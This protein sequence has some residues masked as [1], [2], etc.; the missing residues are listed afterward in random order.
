MRRRR[1]RHVPRGNTLVEFTLVGIPMIFVLISTF[2]IARGMW[3]YHT[4]AYAMKDAARYAA[5]HGQ[6]C[7]GAS[8]G[9]ALRV[10]DLAQRI[11]DAGLGLCTPGFGPAPNS[12]T[13]TIASNARSIVCRPDMTACL[14][15]VT[16]FPTAA[17]CSQAVTMAALPGMPI[18][19]TAEYPFRSAISMFWPGGGPGKV[20]GLYRFPAV[21]RENILF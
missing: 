20:F 14:A 4:M 5:V 13:V 21:A 11:C 10:Q 1:H 3:L 15:D 16:C 19:I 18:T 9:C 7:V 8:A 6:L 17:D 12:L 2:E